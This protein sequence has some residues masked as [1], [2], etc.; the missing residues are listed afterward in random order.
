MTSLYVI[1]FKC[2][3]NFGE[4]QPNPTTSPV[5]GIAGIKALD[6]CFLLLLPLKLWK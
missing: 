4:A 3:L 2:V 1:D 5:A 6:T